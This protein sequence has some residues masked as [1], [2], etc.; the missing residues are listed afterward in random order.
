MFFSNESSTPKS[1][2]YQANY[3]NAVQQLAN[4]MKLKADMLFSLGWLR[5]RLWRELKRVVDNTPQDEFTNYGER[6]HDSPEMRFLWAFMS[7]IQY[8]LK[9]IRCQLDNVLP[10]EDPAQQLYDERNY[11]IEEL[12]SIKYAGQLYLLIDD[13]QSW[14]KFARRMPFN[15]VNGQATLQQFF[16]LLDR[17]S[18]ITDILCGNG[19]K[20]NIF[21]DV[22]DLNTVRT[23]Q[24]Q[25]EM[26]DAILI[27]ALESCYT[28]FNSKSAWAAV[29]CVM[30]DD[31][32]YQNMSDFERNIAQLS[33]FKIS[34]QCPLGTIS[35]ALSDNLYMK[36]PIKTWPA[37]SKFTKF[38]KA[39]RQ[40]IQEELS[41]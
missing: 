35:K 41:K 34:K 1:N 31:Y 3:S 21:I 26:S 11:L 37:S 40:A 2:L 25:L 19:A 20:Y 36:K 38:A 30:R 39:L 9:D 28:Y 18:L 23:E 8:S 27:K 13:D 5:K 29:F 33:F 14:R 17:I 16:Q 4:A 32:G 22:A 6:L 15:D 24:K 12:A 10:R 7:N